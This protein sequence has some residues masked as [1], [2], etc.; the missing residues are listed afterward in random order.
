MP[1]ETMITVR[2][3]AQLEVEPEIALLGVVVAARDRDRARAVQTLAARSHEIGDLISGYG[4]GVQ[5]LESRPVRVQPVFKDGKVRNAPIGFIAQ[6][7][8]SVTVSDFTVLGELVAAL[9]SQDLVT[10]SGPAWELKPASPVYR[11]VRLAA[12]RDSIQRARDYAEAFGGRVTGLAEAADTGLLSGQ[13]AGGQRF[14]AA[15]GMAARS[16]A[17]DEPVEIDLIPVTQTVYA[18]LEARFLMTGP[19]LPG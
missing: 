7:G 16:P 11:E 19:T 18:Q 8:F 9:G 12:A 4:E 13:S 14:V 17:A 15:R 2:G 5:R 3:E 1:G 6:G 10:L